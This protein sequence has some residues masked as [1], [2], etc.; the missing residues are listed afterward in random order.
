[1][2][3][4][5]TPVCGSILEF[6]RKITQDD[7][8][9]ITNRLRSDFNLIFYKSDEPSILES[10]KIPTRVKNVKATLYKNG[11]LLVRGDAATLE[12]QH[13]VDTVTS[14]LDHDGV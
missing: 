2:D 1:M 7:F 5:E 6:V 9:I 3:R 4:A 12:Y 11:T 8:I 10:F 14:I 13:V